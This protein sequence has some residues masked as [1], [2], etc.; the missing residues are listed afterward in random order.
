MAGSWVVEAKSWTL[1][2][3]MVGRLV[4]VA[5]EE[6]EWESPILVVLEWKRLVSVKLENMREGDVAM[7][8]PA[9]CEGE[10]GLSIEC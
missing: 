5:A 2:V 7:I 6:C 8:L 3:S 4:A 1:V 10:G 9:G